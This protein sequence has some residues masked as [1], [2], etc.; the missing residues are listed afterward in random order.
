MMSLMSFETFQETIKKELPGAEWKFQTPIGTIN[1]VKDYYLARSMSH[2]GGELVYDPAT[3]EG[4]VSCYQ[5]NFIYSLE[6]GIEQIRAVQ[7]YSEKLAAAKALYPAQQ[8]KRDCQAAI[9]TIVAELRSKLIA[10]LEKKSVSV[11]A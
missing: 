7:E 11:A 4:H 8:S 2:G 10:I 5:W 3:G 6:Q 1:G 9:D